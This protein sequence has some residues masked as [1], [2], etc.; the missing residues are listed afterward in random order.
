MPRSSVI[1]R[2]RYPPLKLPRLPLTLTAW[3]ALFERLG[4]QI[5]GPPIDR[6]I[7][8]VGGAGGVGSVAIQLAH[9]VPG[10]TV[11]AT[12][13]RA[14][15][16]G[17]CERLGAHAVIDH[18]SDMAAQLASLG[19]ASPDLILLLNDPDRHYPALAEILAPQGK[20]CSIVPFEQPPDMNLIMRK[21]ASFMWEF[22]FT[23]PMF[24]KPCRM[25]CVYRA[26]ENC[27]RQKPVQLPRTVLSL[28]DTR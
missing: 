23:K 10:L 24:A 16:R 9:L 26:L 20:I 25:P 11:I 18:F 27:A 2:C 1:D 4:L 8:I 3:E 22:M 7:L 19:R 17:W 28:G 15:S 12:A 5:A 13:S 21:S 14:Q 6:T